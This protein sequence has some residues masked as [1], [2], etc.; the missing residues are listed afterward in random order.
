[1]TININVHNGSLLGLGLKTL[2][3]PKPVIQLNHIFLDRTWRGM[4]HIHSS[5]IYALNKPVKVKP[6]VL[7][8]WSTVTVPFLTLHVEP[9][10]LHL[11]LTY[12]EWFLHSNT[13]S[14]FLWYPTLST[15]YY[16]TAL[17]QCNMEYFHGVNIQIFIMRA[18]CLEQ[19][20]GRTKRLGLFQH[21]HAHRL[22]QERRGSWLRIASTLPWG[23]S[24]EQT[25]LVDYIKGN[26]AGWQGAGNT[27]ST[28]DG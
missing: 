21:P 26:H 14:V 1:M 10:M 28:S 3:L 22:C 18:R 11:S 20:G 23:R 6:E 24:R 13:A 9:L 17:T 25:L 12:R 8:L 15:L 27:G 16:L 7:Y 4:P 2:M 19:T 5:I